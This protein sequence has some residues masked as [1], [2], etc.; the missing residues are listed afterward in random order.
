[1]SNGLRNGSAVARQLETR[2]HGH[3]A[4]AAVQANPLTGNLLVLFDP[5][6]LTVRELIAEVVR[7]RAPARRR[8]N[9][10]GGRVTAPRSAPPDGPAWHALPARAVVRE[11]EVAPD[12]GLSGVEAER[13]LATVGPNRLPAPE[14]RSA[15]ATL[16][17]QVASLPVGL[18]AGAA[19][20]SL[21]GGAVFDALVILGVVGI[22]A[23]VGYVTERRVDRIL[24]GLRN[25]TVPTALVR[26]DGK[27]TFL[28][29]AA[30][31]PGDVVVLQAGYDVPADGRVIAADRLALDESA[32]TGE[33]LPV[34]K[35][36]GTVYAPETLLADRAN[37]VYS[38]TSVAEGSGLALVTGTGVATEMGRIRQLIA[39]AVAPPTPLERELDRMGRRLVGLCLG[40]S[41]VALGLGLL[42]GVAALEMLRTSISLAVAAVPEGLPAVAT[43][44]L[45]LGMQRML[46]RNALIRRLSAVESLGATTVICVDKTGTLT[47]NRMSVHAWHLGGSDLVVNGRA[48]ELSDPRLRWAHM[49]GVLCN[50]ADLTRQQGG[51]WEVNGSGTEGALL[52]A[53]RQAGLDYRRLREDHPLVSLRPRLA[54]ENWMA[55]VHEAGPG[56]RLMMVKGAPEEVVRLCARRLDGATAPGLDDDARRSILEA[57]AALANQGMRVLGLAFKEIPAAASPS[58][59]DLAWVGLVGLRDPIREGVREAIAACQRA[60]IRTIMITGDQ[61]LTALAVARELD[62]V[63]NGQMRV[64]EAS[65]LG[66]ASEAAV[67]NFARDVAVFARVSPAHKYQIVRALQAEGEIVAMTGDGIN[68]APALKAAD[69]GVAMGARGT[70]VARDLA[71]VV[72]LDDNFGSIVGAVEQGRTIHAN[73][74]KALRFLLATNFSEILVTIGALALGIAR[75]LT[76]IQLLWINLLSDVVPALAL[77]VEPAEPDIMARPPRDPAAPVLSG[78]ALLRIAGDGALLSATTLG[79]YGAALARHGAGPQAASVAF[80][81]L[82]SGQ[83]LYALTCRSEHRPAVTGLHRSPALLGAVGGTVALQ[84]AAVAVPS[85]RRLLGIAPLGPGDWGLVAAG[86]AL[87]LLVT[88]VTKALRARPV[89]TAEPTRRR[90]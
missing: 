5:A 52:A 84:V 58:Y 89:L 3:Q 71:D 82:A 23:A 64:V 36:A 78:D 28:P 59:D 63:R 46:R 69:I 19:A 86:A 15:L 90:R 1:M 61:S 9:G 37:M 65:Q 11:L 68:D 40:L 41:S 76:A 77:A 17:D 55:T 47:E 22:N 27:E 42:R 75:P 83:L 2:L 38:G 31:V 44:T 80:A 66:G 12:T 6:R 49:I 74:G 43:T 18:L 85:L 54:D 51:G 26:R 50:E 24:G 30:L 7:S 73:V 29:A 62:L 60:G 67:R 25:A 4:I 13:R 8:R 10:R 53:A 70:Q 21:A 48:A 72:L 88:E 35:A 56:R 16:W 45:A 81:T 14:P 32:L 79:A 20:L 57:N 34:P 39:A 87:P 33:S